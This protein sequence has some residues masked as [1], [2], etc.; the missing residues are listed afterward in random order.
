MNL[1]ELMDEYNRTK[2]QKGEPVMTQRRLAELTGVAEATVSRHVNGRTGVDLTQAAA[3]AK[4]LGV[5][6]E[7]LIE[8]PAA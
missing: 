5:P 4:A 7:A 3:Y 6:I 8:E 1:V 2:R